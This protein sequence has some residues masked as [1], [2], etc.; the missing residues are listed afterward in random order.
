MLAPPWPMTTPIIWALALAALGLSLVL[1][2][3]VW[4][5]NIF[6]IMILL[7]S[8][9]A[10]FRLGVMYAFG[11]GLMHDVCHVAPLGLE[12]SLLAL[13]VYAYR[14][15][16]LILARQSILVSA[17]AITLLFASYL[18]LQWFWWW[19]WN[20]IPSPITL[21]NIL[22]QSIINAVCFAVLRA[23]FYSPLHETE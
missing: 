11:A 19:A 9:Y 4:A 5:P 3:R 21:P 7:I 16:H 23:L 10:F 12:A 1:P 8:H 2:D 14:K 20:G 13:L 22:I 6:V 15:I 18:V 17:L